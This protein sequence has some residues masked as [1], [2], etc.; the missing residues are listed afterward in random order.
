MGGGS[1]RRQAVAPASA[2]PGPARP[3]TGAEPER[4]DAPADERQPHERPDRLG[5][6]RKDKQQPRD[7]QD[8][9][10]DRPVEG[11]PE[12][13]ELR[14]RVAERDGWPR[15]AARAARSRAG[16]REGGARWRVAAAPEAPGAAD[17][18]WHARRA[19]GR[20]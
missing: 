9:T 16:D 14:Q 12:Q 3:A 17:R 18:W 13:G 20:P 1:R 2:S 10:R 4:S 8:Q 15:P 11:V 19:A 5:G 7:R 6:D